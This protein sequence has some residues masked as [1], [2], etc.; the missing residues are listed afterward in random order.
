M[1]ITI[2][3][4]VFGSILTTLVTQAHAVC[5]QIAPNPNPVDGVIKITSTI[6]C[7]ELTPFENFGTLF[8]ISGELDNF[9][10]L[11]NFGKQRGGRNCR[12]LDAS[13]DGEYIFNARKRAF[14]YPIRS[15]YVL[16]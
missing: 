4:V 10:T 5:D 9:G 15:E 2:P 3:A 13:A 12:A 1:R 8:N 11:D 6:S 16:Q 7:N 14:K